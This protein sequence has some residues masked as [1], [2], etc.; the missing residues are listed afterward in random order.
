MFRYR[1]AME[2]GCWVLISL[3]CESLDRKSIV[4]QIQMIQNSANKQYLPC[5]FD[6]FELRCKSRN[7]KLLNVTVIHGN[8]ENFFNFLSCYRS[9]VFA[10]VVVVVIIVEM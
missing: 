4:K 10:A 5:K 7:D 6:A 3:L 8:Y 9:R 2:V 1:W